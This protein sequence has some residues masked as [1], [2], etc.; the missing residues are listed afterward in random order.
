MNSNVARSGLIDLKASLSSGSRKGDRQTHVKAQAAIPTTSA[1]RSSLRESSLGAL[2][3]S[4]VIIAIDYD[5][6]RESSSDVRA[7]QV[8]VPSPRNGEIRTAERICAF[9]R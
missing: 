8:A 4:V 3:A 7:S 6:N 2:R 9:S 1:K 5:R